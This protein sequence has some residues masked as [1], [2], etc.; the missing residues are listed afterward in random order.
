[1]RR[2]G[3]RKGEEQGKRVDAGVLVCWW[4]GVAVWL[5]IFAGLTLYL[6]SAGSQ[7]SGPLQNGPV[8][9]IDLK[10]LTQR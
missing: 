4:G 10:Q 7:D 6:S 3:R 9:K 8:M 2:V 5:G 1:V